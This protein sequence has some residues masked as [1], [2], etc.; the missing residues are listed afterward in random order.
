MKAAFAAVAVAAVV[1]PCAAFAPSPWASRVSTSVAAT[2]DRR[3]AIGNI[4]KLM[5]GAIVAAGAD[6]AFAASN[7]ALGGWR[8]KGKGGGDGTFKPGKGM[9]EKQSFDEL[10]SA[11][12]P[13]LGGW[14]SKGKGGGDGTFKPGKGMRAHQS[15]DELVAASNPA[16]GGWRSKGKGGGDG[17]F[18]PGKGMR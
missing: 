10:V 15:F 1:S 6:P 2:S 14:R 5:G 18:K 3:D 7:P 9:R 11:S 17:T 16:L 8:S 4:A 12:N 13:A